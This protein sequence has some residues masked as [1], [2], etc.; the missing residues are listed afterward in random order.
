[1]DSRRIFIMKLLFV[2]LAVALVITVSPAGDPLNN[3]MWVHIG[4]GWRARRRTTTHHVYLICT[5]ESL[6]ILERG[7]DIRF[8]EPLNTI[9]DTVIGFDKR[10]EDDDEGPCESSCAPNVSFKTDAK[11]GLPSDSNHTLW[12]RDMELPE[13]LDPTAMDDFMRNEIPQAEEIVWQVREGTDMN[14]AIIQSYQ[15][16]NAFSLGV[17]GLCGCTS[18]WIISRQGVYAT[19]YWESISFRP[20]RIWKLNSKES[21]R[22]VFDRTVTEGLRNGI[23]AG[24][25]IQQARLDP[26][27][28]GDQNIRGYIVRPEKSCGKKPRVNGYSHWWKLIRSTVSEIIPAL[29]PTI[30]PDRWRDIVYNR[31]DRNDMDLINRAYGHVLFKYDPDHNGKRKAALWV[32]HNAV[33]YHDDEW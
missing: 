10:E 28:L 16:P 11:R 21:T 15:T 19:H 2:I 24:A 25:E 23:G 6:R 4:R 27:L 29:D 7:G 30:Y 33:P 1:M 32:E 14:T 3:E 17:A 26:A 31:R 9:S 20:D 8:A 12:E 5:S 22:S 18:L 13:G